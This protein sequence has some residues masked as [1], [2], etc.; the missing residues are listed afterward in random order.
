ML[1]QLINIGM[2]QCAFM[3][4]IIIMPFPLRTMTK[5]NKNID[6][7]YHRLTEWEQEQELSMHIVNK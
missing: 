1:E 4:E 7:A 6:M 2:H 3:Q 5:D